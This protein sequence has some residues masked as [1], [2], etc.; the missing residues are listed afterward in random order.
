MARSLF[1]YHATL[2]HQFIPGI[3]ARVLHEGGGY[4]LRTNAAGF[5]CGH[6]FRPERRADTFR[7]L[8][9]GDSYTA[10]DGVSDGQRYGDVLETLLPGVEVF[11]FGLSGTGTDQQYLAWRE[12]GAAIEHD[13]VVIGVLV[14]NIRR[15]VSHYRPFRTHEGDDVAL[16]KPYFSLE[17]GGALSLHHVP[18]PREPRDEGDLASNEAFDRGGRLPALR[19]ALNRLGPGVKDALQRLTRYQPLP[20][21]DRADGAEWGLLEAILRRWLSEL[22]APAIVCPIP[23][24]QYVE[25][26]ASPAGYLARFRSLHAPPSVVVHDPLPAFHAHRRAERR[27]FRFEHDCHLTPAGHRVLAESLATA[28]GPLV[29]RGGEPA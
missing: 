11:N 14:E 4:L 16:A 27:R 6:E 29:A 21:Y 25:E 5:R 10:G 17:P 9:F 1:R 15:V 22:Q 12:Y 23:L 18:V 2:G 3:R 8:L 7:I 26:T 19:I 13:L 24:Y 28:I 20:E